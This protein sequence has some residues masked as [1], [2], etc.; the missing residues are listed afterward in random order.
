MAGVASNDYWL[1][2]RGFFPPENTSD[3]NDSELSDTSDYAD[4]QASKKQKTDETN[5]TGNRIRKQT[6]RYGT[7]ESEMNDDSLF[8]QVLSNR[9][10]SSS[11]TN[12]SEQSIESEIDAGAAES[13]AGS[14]ESEPDI[15]NNQLRLMSPGEKILYGKVT[16]LA[17]EILTLQRIV[18]GLKID[19][20]DRIKGNHEMPAFGEVNSDELVVLGVPLST[21]K[22]LT[23]F[24]DKLKNKVFFGQVVSMKHIS[25][26]L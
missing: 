14:S 10:R 7:Q 17:K 16:E 26:I 9:S 5:T 15:N 8:E 6:Q 3:A 4:K 18:T 20:D 24:E 21:D 2:K 11:A 19:H 13:A 22:E 23:D 25:H 12:Q 1:R